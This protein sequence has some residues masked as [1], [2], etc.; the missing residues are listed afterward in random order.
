MSTFS[1]EAQRVYLAG[2]ISW[3]LSTLI[4]PCSEE[5]SVTGKREERFDSFVPIR[6][7][8]VATFYNNA[9]SNPTALFEPNLSA[10]SDERRAEVLK[11]IEKIK[12]IFSPENL[13]AGA[14]ILRAF[15]KEL[16][17]SGKQTFFTRSAKDAIPIG[18]LK[19]QLENIE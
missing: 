13:I 10:C 4:R 19:R 2:G 9:A 8:D 5:Y 15:D 18:Y 11:D 17:F 14:E 3:A 7:E 1:G 6:S 12:D 16:G